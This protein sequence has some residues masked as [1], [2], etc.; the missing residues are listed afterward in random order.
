MFYKQHIDFS[1]EC[2]FRYCHVYL[3]H[4]NTDIYTRTSVRIKRVRG[5][6][7]REQKERGEREKEEKEDEDLLDPYK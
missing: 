5:R 2:I 6:A 7:K 1:H 3:K 4:Y